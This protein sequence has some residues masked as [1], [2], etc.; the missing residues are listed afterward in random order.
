MLVA[1]SDI[2]SFF[3]RLVLGVKGTRWRLG[4]R[5][6]VLNSQNRVSN[7]RHGYLPAR[8]GFLLC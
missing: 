2:S 1:V 8:R 7:E 6:C 3:S 5:V 4:C